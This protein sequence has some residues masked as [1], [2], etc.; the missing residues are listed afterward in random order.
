MSAQAPA[1]GALLSA[2]LGDGG[3]LLVLAN[4]PDAVEAGRSRLA[5]FLDRYA[6]APEALNR[7]E[8]V[9]EELVSNVIRH[10]FTPG[11]GQTVRVRA[12]ATADA[13]RLVIEDDG[14][15]FD[16]LG[17]SDPEAFGS[18]EEATLGGLGIPLVRKL[19]SGLRYERASAAADASGFRPV[20]R[21][22]VTAPTGR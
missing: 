21:L 15:P 7:L 14:V 9:F 5:G 2:E 11:S 17:R 16:P 13:V 8:V 1:D 3:I 6:L 20:N 12:T 18:L 19:C 22:L 4:S 10:G